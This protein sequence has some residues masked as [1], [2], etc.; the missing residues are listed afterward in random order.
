MTVHF[1]SR[2]ALTAKI[3]SSRHKV[4]PEITIHHWKT[5]SKIIGSLGKWLKFLTPS[6]DEKITLVRNVLSFLETVFRN[7]F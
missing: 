6:V 2:I 7:F 5:I 3:L 4:I 1:V